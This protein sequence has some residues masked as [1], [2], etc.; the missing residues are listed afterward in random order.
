MNNYKTPCYV[1]SKSRFLDNLNCVKSNF[2]KC[3]S[4]NLLLGYSI[5]TNHDPIFLK[6]ALE[7]NMVAEAVSGEEYKFAVNRGFCEKN[8]IFNGP[9]KTKEDLRYALENGSI[10]NVDNLSE[11]EEIRSFL[12]ALDISKIKVGLRVNFNLEE[13]C[14][15]ETTAGKDVSRFGIC[16]ENGDFEIAVKTLKSLK[17]KVSG[18]HLHYSTKTRSVKVFEALALKACEIVERYELERD[19]EFIDIGGGFFGGQVVL[20]KPTMKEYSE[21]ICNVLKNT[22]DPQ[23][24]CLILEPGASILATTTSYYTQ[25]INVRN[26][27]DV[28]VVTVDGSILHINP[29]MIP[30]KPVAQVF[31][32]GN[33]KISEQIICGATCMEND[34]FLS[35]ENKREIVMN[36][37]IKIDNV[38]AYTMGFNSCFI[39]TPPYVYF[40]D[41]K[42]CVCVREKDVNLFDS[43]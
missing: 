1:I 16:L 15:G 21:N 10:V 8:I 11:L 34:R 18:L 5:K 6:I 38:G 19:I 9:Q 13:Y 28:S 20:G 14:K 32:S 30:R 27:R 35:F 4:E 2:Q 40:D 7:Q 12:S 25:V 29:L 3:W 39:N 43:I 33:K 23:K 31:S 42:N 41:G 22:F 17:I 36:D 37:Y 26:I 24:V